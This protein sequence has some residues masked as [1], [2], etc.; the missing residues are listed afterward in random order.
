ML[1]ELVIAAAVVLTL[2]GSVF[3]LLDPARGALRV[4]PEVAEMHQRMRVVFARLH[5]DLMMAG[6]GPHLVNGSMVAAL[7][8]PV[9]PA[10][11]GDRHRSGAGT[12]FA[13]DA[14]SVLHADSRDAGAMLAS[15]LVG[16][17]AEVRLAHGP[18]CVET[19][20]GCGLEGNSVALVFDE[21]GRSDLFRV[22]SVRR[23]L[24]SVELL[25][26]GAVQPFPAGAWI[27]P[28]QL[29]GYDL[30]PSADRIR[31]RN[32]WASDMPLLDNV[33][34]LSFRYFGGS[35]LPEVDP[36]AGPVA[37]CLAAA[38][39]GGGSPVLASATEVELFPTAL[40]DGPWCGGRIRYD[41]DLFR[42][43]RV[44]VSIRLQVA[45]DHLRGRDPELFVRPGS[46]VQGSA[47]V[48][49]YVASFEVA[50]R[51]ALANQ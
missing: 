43:R 2:L 38:L 14:I 42:V 47:L 15:P 19:P 48:P 24:I 9:M 10:R 8:P 32:G 41:V 20:P 29:R 40:T 28:V 6:S 7:R 49:D 34:G 30:D 3:S 46:A 23:D 44:R 1:A 11:V 26:G 25:G 51:N 36:A 45:D 12:R 5:G 39:R 18:P 13:P 27:V 37:P 35:T 17:T 16:P 50:P 21:T 22:T 4:E 31:Y 33:V